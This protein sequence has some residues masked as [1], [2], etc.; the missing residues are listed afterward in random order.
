MNGGAGRVL[1]DEAVILHRRP[2]RETSLLLD[3]FSKAHGRLRLLA[4]GAK[5]GRSPQSGFLQP[6]RRLRLSWSGRGELPVL[7]GSEPIGDPIPLDGTALFCGFYLNELVLHLLASH[8][9][10]PEVFRLYL[11]TLDQLRPEAGRERVLRL[12]EVSLLEEI[13]YGLSLDREAE[14]RDIDPAKTYTYVLD[15]GPVAVAGPVPEAVRGATLLGLGRRRLDSPEQL[16]EAKH[17]LR[18]VIQHHLNG[19]SLKSRELFKT[20][21][22]S[23]AP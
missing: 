18:R 7:T 22:K 8:D 21:A 12:F 15:E 2:Y 4:K 23:P 11:D 6:F 17:L 9:P 10:H 16:R 20:L 1:L 3:V 13:G 5:R 14:G 19:R